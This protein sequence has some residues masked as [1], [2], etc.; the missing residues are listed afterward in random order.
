MTEA[1]VIRTRLIEH[2]GERP[3][4]DRRD[5]TMGIKSIADDGD[6]LMRIAKSKTIGRALPYGEFKISDTMT[7]ELHCNQDLDTAKKANVVCRKLIKKF[8][9]GDLKESNEIFEEE[10]RK[11]LEDME[12]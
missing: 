6:V 8:M 4:E 12:D 5:Y 9:N 10:A 1:R 7:V 3:V 11:M 2:K